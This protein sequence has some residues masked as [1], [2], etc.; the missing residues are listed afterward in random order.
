MKHSGDRFSLGDQAFAK[1]LERRTFPAEAVIFAEGD[2]AREAFVILRGEVDIVSTN[3]NKERVVLT[4]LSKGQLF[5]DLALMA[6][7]RRTASAVARAP[8]ELMALSQEVLKKKLEVADPLLR[9]WIAYLGERVIAL[10]K[11]AAS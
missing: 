4:T 8:C 1:V 11:R 10:S 3:A 2:I 6:D 5:G 9:F 7:S